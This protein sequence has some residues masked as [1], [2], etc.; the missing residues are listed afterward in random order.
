MSGNLSVTQL[1]GEETSV[2][3]ARR[4]VREKLIGRGYD[5][6]VMDDVELLVSELLT[7]AII[8]TFSKFDGVTLLL[9][10]RPHVIHVEIADS[11]SS[12]V[13]QM[14]KSPEGGRANGEGGR[15]LLIVETLASTWGDFR[16]DYGRVVWFEIN[17]KSSPA[18]GSTPDGPVSVR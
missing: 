6:E 14:R 17:T 8:H 18:L 7:N 16:D 10:I 1:P 13:P 15:G 4:F 2:A 5:A 12:S 3:K 11:G 9:A